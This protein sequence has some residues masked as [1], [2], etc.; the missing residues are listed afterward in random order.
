MVKHLSEQEQQTAGAV[1]SGKKQS[2][3]EFGDLK[4]R[5]DAQKWTVDPFN[6]KRSR[7]LSV[8]IAI[9][10]NGQFRLIPRIT[11]HAAVGELLKRA[12]QMEV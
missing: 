8:D 2:E 9:I 1:D 3:L 11:P 7:S 5:A 12:H 6:S 10:V 4:C